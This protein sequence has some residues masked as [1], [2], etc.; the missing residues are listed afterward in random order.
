[1]ASVSP[2]PRETS[3]AEILAATARAV[4][5][6]GPS[7][8]TLAEVAAEARV[9][10]ATLV[11]RFG[12]KRQLLLALAGSASDDL[13]REFSAIRAAAR[14]PLDAVYGVGECMAAMAKTPETFSNSLAFLQIDLVDPEFHRLALAHARKMRVEIKKLLDEAVRARELRPGDTGR[15]AQAIAG[16]L[17]GSL[18]QWA[19]ER[20][21]T[22]RKRLRADLE[23]LLKPR[24]RSRR[25]RA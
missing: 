15:L 21:G 14:T 13:E 23:T 9:S 25:S 19:I 3:D 6:L 5:R 8:L 24:H 22:A 4:S 11:Q 1:M 17:S 7:K 18:L 10:A 16:M 12:S 2:R 20:D